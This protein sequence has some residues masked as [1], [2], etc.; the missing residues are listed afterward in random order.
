MVGRSAGHPFVLLSWCGESLVSPPWLRSA[1]LGLGDKREYTV[2]CAKLTQVNLAD[3]F[4]LCLFFRCVKS[5]VTFTN[6]VPEWHPLNAAH[7]GPCNN[8]N[9]KSQIRKMVLER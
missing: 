1:S 8:C 6:V 7:F 3:G 9:S 2:G 5:L 4:K